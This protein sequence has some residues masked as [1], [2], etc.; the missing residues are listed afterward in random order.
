MNKRPTLQAPSTPKRR[1]ASRLAKQSGHKV[2][3][4]VRQ[5]PRRAEG[6]RFDEVLSLIAAARQR[7]Y[8]AVNTE[9]V[10]LYWELGGF[11]SRKISSAEWGDGVVDELAAT[12]AREYPG[13][14]GFT[15]PNRF[16]M[17][18]FF[19]AYEGGRKSLSTTETIAQ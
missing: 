16:R 4:L 1:V 10:G 12:I 2:A 6:G 11:I 15:R 7:A 14:R 8:Q 5:W 19:E 3:T 17:R 18:Q 13:L 9:L